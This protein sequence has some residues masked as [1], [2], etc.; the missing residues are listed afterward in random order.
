[1]TPTRLRYR[2][3]R[4]GFDLADRLAPK[5][6]LPRLDAEALIGAAGVEP[7]AA[8]R[9][10]LRRL[11]AA[12]AAESE[13]NLLGRLMIRWDMIRLLRNAA[14]IAQ[15]H[16]EDPALAA[17][18]VPAPIFVLGLPRSGTTFLRTRTTWCRVT[19]R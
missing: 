5:A 12:L 16:A 14:A 9:E 18:A 13:L 6:L 19:G 7:S 4:S 17:A 15:A 2:T 8:A 1:M 10:G 3:L 11:M